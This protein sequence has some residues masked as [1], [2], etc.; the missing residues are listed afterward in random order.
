[1]AARARAE[2]WDDD[3]VALLLAWLPSRAPDT[4]IRITERAAE[5]ELRGEV[6]LVIRRFVCPDYVRLPGS[7]RCRSFIEGGACSRAEH[8]ICIE[9]QRANPHR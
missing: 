8:P 4:P 9:W 6:R 7:R 3:A 5:L 1:M 2:G